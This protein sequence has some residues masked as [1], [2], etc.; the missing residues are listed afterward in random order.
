MRKIQWFILAIWVVSFHA[1]TAQIT[2]TSASMPAANDTIRYSTASPSGI[3]TSWKTKGGNQT[4]D[5]ST[6]TSTGQALNEY[7]SANKTPYAFYFFGQIGQKTAD[8][9]GGGPFLFKNIYSFYSKSTTVFKAEG[10]GYTISG[11]PLA[12]MYSDED[13]IYQ[14][15]LQYNDSDVSKFRFVFSIPGQTLFTFIQAGKRTNVVDAWGSIKTP[16]K[17]YNDAIRVFTIVDEVDTLATQFSKTPIPR[18]TVSYKW[19]ATSEKIPVL[20]IIGTLSANGTFTPTVINYRDKY[21]ANTNSNGMVADFTVD[22][23]TGTVVV[24]TFTFTNTT[25]PFSITNTWTFTPSMGVKF[26]S[27]TSATSRDVRV[28]FQLGG[29]LYTVNLKA[30]AGILSD[31][32]TYNDLIFIGWGLNSQEIHK[33]V[34]FYPNPTK[35][36]IILEG[37]TS[38]KNAT[39]F[40]SQGQVV[41]NGL[42]KDGKID[43]RDLSSGIY[44][45]KVESGV[46]QFIKQD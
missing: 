15:P 6:L 18:K 12:S 5:F 34:N 1:L 13:E 7:K 3:G 32:T 10:L 41:K 33:V 46:I 44:Y 31:D 20:E 21:L 4:W 16:Y 40:N 24:D 19:L 36:F 17:T 9:L 30:S 37:Q 35:D 43:V 22:K 8:S 2:I 38:A 26:V 29:G 11:I 45:L 23:D 14:F 27:G 39:I 42:V 28:V 25:K